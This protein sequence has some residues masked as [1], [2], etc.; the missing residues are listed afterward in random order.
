[1]NSDAFDSVENDNDLEYTDA[2]LDAAIAASDCEL[3]PPSD[4]DPDAAAAG[5]KKNKAAST[6]QATLVAKL[7][8]EAGVELYHDADSRAFADVAVGGHRELWPVRGAATRRYLTRLYWERHR[9]A[10]GAAAMLRVK[11][12]RAVI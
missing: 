8:I 7:A 4:D 10:V 3:P 5:K 6:S 9:A 1:M 11:G 2:D 12:R